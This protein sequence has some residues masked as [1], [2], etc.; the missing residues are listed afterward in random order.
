MYMNMY[1]SYVVECVVV[2][3]MYI[4]YVVRRMY[5]MRYVY[6]L[7]GYIICKYYLTIEF[8]IPICKYTYL[9]EDNCMKI[10]GEV[11]YE[12]NLC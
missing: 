7:Y 9:Y 4:A 3:C 12:D 2:N 6:K 1:V 11:K 5:I 10:S 8:C